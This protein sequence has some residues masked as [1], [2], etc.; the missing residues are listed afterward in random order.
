MEVSESDGE[1][2]KKTSGRPLG[3]GGEESWEATFARSL[4]G[5]L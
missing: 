5:T 1:V 4:A 2:G 3:L